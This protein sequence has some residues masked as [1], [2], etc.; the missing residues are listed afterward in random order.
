[1]SLKERILKM[2]MDKQKEKLDDEENKLEELEE[3][4][5]DGWRRLKDNDEDNEKIRDGDYVYTSAFK[6]IYHEQKQLLE[7]D[8]SDSE[9]DLL[10]WQNNYVRN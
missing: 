4:R 7:L 3:I 6:G 9:D 10:Q 1:M 5:V 8:L 2:R